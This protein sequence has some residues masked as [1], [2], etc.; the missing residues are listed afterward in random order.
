MKTRFSSYLTGIIQRLNFKIIFWSTAPYSG[1]LDE[2]LPHHKTFAHRGRRKQRRN[3]WYTE[4]VKIMLK[5]K[6]YC[7]ITYCPRNVCPGFLV[8]VCWTRRRTVWDLPVNHLT[9]MMYVLWINGFCNLSVNIILTNPVYRCH[10]LYY[11]PLSHGWRDY[12][13]PNGQCDLLL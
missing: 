8:F 3:A 6:D 1:L 9:H 12:S 7:G 13:R 2:T 11:I 10:K 5:L 4:L